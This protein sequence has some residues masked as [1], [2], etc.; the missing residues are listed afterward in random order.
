MTR[1][2]SDYSFREI[3]DFNDGCIQFDVVMF[4]SVIEFKIT[5]SFRGS[6]R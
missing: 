2:I 4:D 5:E 6:V 3:R 1:Q